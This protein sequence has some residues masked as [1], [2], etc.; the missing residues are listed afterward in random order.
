M[1]LASLNNCGSAPDPLTFNLSDPA[2]STRF[3][4]PSL[5]SIPFVPEIRSA[6]KQ[7]DRDDVLF[8]FVA[9]VCLLRDAARRI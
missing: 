7:C 5:D 1:N 3:S 4:T 2:K 8:E 9:A 6:N